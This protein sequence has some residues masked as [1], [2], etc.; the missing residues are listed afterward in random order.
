MHSNDYPDVFYQS[1]PPISL[2]FMS[3]DAAQIYDV[4]A[5]DTSLVRINRFPSNKQEY[6]GN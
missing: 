5:E 3:R 2:H 4:A 6:H 1:L